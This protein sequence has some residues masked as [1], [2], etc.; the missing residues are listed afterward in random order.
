MTDIP[1]P[2]T[3]KTKTAQDVASL[4]KRVDAALREADLKHARKQVREAERG[5]AE[6]QKRL[7]RANAELRKL[8]GQP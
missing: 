1:S 8:E 6:A 2:Q 4:Q 5:V 7:D 3:T